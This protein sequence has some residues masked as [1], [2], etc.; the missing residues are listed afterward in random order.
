MIRI[1]AIMILAMLGHGFLMTSGADGASCPARAAQVAAVV[2]FLDCFDH[3]AGCF[4]VQGVVK[5]A[6]LALRWVALAMPCPLTLPSDIPV[7][8]TAPSPPGRPPDVARVLL[9]VYR[10]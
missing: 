2:P 6:P 9:Q 3:D 10:M 7:A 1:A 8:S 4:T 5:S